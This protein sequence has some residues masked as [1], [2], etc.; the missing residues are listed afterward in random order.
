MNDI[1]E[2]FKCLDSV[3]MVKGTVKTELG[4][5]YTYYSNCYDLK[6]KK[7]YYKSYNKPEIRCVS[8]QKTL[9]TNFNSL[10]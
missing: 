1:N 7:L 3:S 9:L 10:I 6:Q 4:F 8:M 5:E 2:F